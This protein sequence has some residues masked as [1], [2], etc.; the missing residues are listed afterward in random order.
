MPDFRYF[1]DITAKNR[2]DA[3]EQLE[4]MAGGMSFGDLDLIELPDVQDKQTAIQLKEFLEIKNE[5]EVLNKIQQFFEGWDGWFCCIDNC[6]ET[7]GCDTGDM[8]EHLLTHTKEEL[9]KEMN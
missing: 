1:L 8:F 6:G 5:N 9:V 2:D 3:Q 7:I 4:E